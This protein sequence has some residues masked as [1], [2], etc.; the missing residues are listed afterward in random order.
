[1]DDHLRPAPPMGAL[2]EYLTGLA[3]ADA[4]QEYSDT[5]SLERW[6]QIWGDL[7]TNPATEG[8]GVRIGYE[9]A[10]WGIGLATGAGVLASMRV[11]MGE[12]LSPRLWVQDRLILSLPSNGA[13][14][15]QIVEVEWITA[16]TGTPM[17]AVTIVASRGYDPR[18]FIG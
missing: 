11:K 16:G 10:D 13:T 1:M 4:A 12:V 17:I 6:Y 18:R 9:P 15:L 14:D 8:V 2:G 3:R 5:P 7:I